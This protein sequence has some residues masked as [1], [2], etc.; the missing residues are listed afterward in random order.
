MEIERQFLIAVIPVL[1]QEYDSILQGYVSLLPEIRIRQVRKP[2]N[3]EFFYLTVK[4]GKGLMREEWETKISSREFS[5]L[6]ERLEPDTLFIEKRRYYLP[7]D[8][9]HVAEFHRHEAALKG[10]NYVEVEFSSEE[11]ANAFEPPAWFGREVTEDPRFTYGR[12][13]AEN[14]MELA[15]KI[16]AQPYNDIMPAEDEE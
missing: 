16:M 15:K 13:A 4:R 2:D 11:E 6:V 3:Q 14:G 12:L 8:D 10:F 1:P 9:G 5:H 7:L